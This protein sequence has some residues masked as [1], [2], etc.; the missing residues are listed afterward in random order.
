MLVPETCALNKVFRI[1]HTQIDS[2]H[3]NASALIFCDSP[4]PLELSSD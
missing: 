2:V 1:A 3:V 4:E